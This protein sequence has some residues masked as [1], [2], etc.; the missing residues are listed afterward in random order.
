[1]RIFR[2]GPG[3]H[4]LGLAMAGVKLGE[5]LLD[6]GAA[7]SGL[8]AELAG[9]VGLTGRACAIVASEDAATR[10]KAAAARAGVLVEVEV[11]SWPGL[12]VGDSE[13]DLALLDA[14]DGVLE[15]LDEG[16]RVGLAREAR[17][18]LRDGGRLLVL[19]REPA[20]WRR[21]LG[22]RPTGAAEFH[23]QGG[24]R[25]VLELAGFAPVRVLAEREGQRFTEGW[26]IKKATG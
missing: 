20:G 3:P 7:R 8:F 14:T 15:A 21:A 13:F 9:K 18:A 5:R 17:R 26:K 12:P 4:A 11:T 2:P 22:G 1:M 24:A 10:V 19:E 6:I 23:R 16:S 25:A